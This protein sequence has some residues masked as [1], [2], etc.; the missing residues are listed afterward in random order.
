MYFV[1]FE[2]SNG[3]DVYFARVDYFFFEMVVL[4]SMFVGNVEVV[5]GFVGEYMVNVICCVIVIGFVVEI[6]FD[7][8]VVGLEATDSILGCMEF[9]DVG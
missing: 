2:N 8:I 7:V 1:D 3:A 9:V 5:V 6:F 4:L